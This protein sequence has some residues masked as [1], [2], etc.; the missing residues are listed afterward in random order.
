MT[1][2][3]DPLENELEGL[4]PREPSPLLEHRLSRRLAQRPTG[5]PATTW[6]L[7]LVAGVAAALLLGLALSWL[8]TPR[9]DSIAP[10]R[11]DAP[12]WSATNASEPA[13]LA[14]YRRAWEA[15]P[16]KLEELL[17]RQPVGFAQK[18]A[19][20]PRLRDPQLLFR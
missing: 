17:D 4:R 12:E 14:S 6:R 20:V 16:E 19:H 5:D 7:A 13:T 11:H 10:T 9:Q 15:S 8:H 2:E 1:D 18:E 3:R